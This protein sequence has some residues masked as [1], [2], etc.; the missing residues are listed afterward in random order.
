MSDPSLVS[1]LTKAADI[2]KSVTSEAMRNVP[3]LIAAFGTLLF[4]AILPEPYLPKDISSQRWIAIS[5][6]V[7][8]GSYVLLRWW[9][10]RRPVRQLKWH[11]DNLATDER[12]VLA[13]YLK[14]DAACEYFFAFHGPVCS[15]IKKGVLIFASDMFDLF[16]A[17]VMI[18]SHVRKHLRKNPK[19]VGLKPT[20]LGTSRPRGRLKTKSLIQEQ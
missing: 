18:N 11:C 10:A 14:E 17:P 7:F 9:F 3:L 8:T 15:L 12:E 1:H 13:A 6:C 2:V 19:L 5:A 20:D 16:E 4:V